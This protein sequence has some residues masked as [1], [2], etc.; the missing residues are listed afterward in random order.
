MI[1]FTARLARRL[2]RISS[3]REHIIL[4]T[5]PCVLKWPTAALADASAPNSRKESAPPPS[6]CE[7]DH[8]G[9]P[10]TGD[11]SSAA[12]TIVRMNGCRKD[13]THRPILTTSELTNARKRRNGGVSS[14]THLFRAVRSLPLIPLA[15][16]ALETP[17]NVLDHFRRQVNVL[18]PVRIASAGATNASRRRNPTAYP[19]P[20]RDKFFAAPSMSPARSAPILNTPHTSSPEKP[21]RSM[22]QCRRADAAMSIGIRLAIR[23]N[24]RQ[25]N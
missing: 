22:P 7:N 10:S 15:R 18:H 1:V 25:R 2:I 6:H 17:P 16:L 8:S 19:N 12:V 3:A 4:A 21:E 23:R 9:L 11:T 5:R 14:G 13:A 24:S 20:A